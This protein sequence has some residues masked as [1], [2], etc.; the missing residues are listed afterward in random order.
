MGTA[1]ELSGKERI[2]AWES[3]TNHPWVKSQ[4]AAYL[5]WDRSGIPMSIETFSGHLVATAP[6]NSE[7][8]KTLYALHHNDLEY[9]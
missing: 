9:I 2:K 5:K 1:K 6:Q 4:Y 8:G 3:V 7:L